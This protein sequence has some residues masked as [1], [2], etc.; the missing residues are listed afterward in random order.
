MSGSMRLCELITI[1]IRDIG[2]VVGLLYST[3]SVIGKRV[4][5]T[6]KF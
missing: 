2:D 4:Y 5:E 3:I 6:M 1:H